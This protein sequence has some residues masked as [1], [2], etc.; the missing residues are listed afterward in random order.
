M[1]YATGTGKRRG[2]PQSATVDT[3]MPLAHE[4]VVQRKKVKES[5]E[6]SDEEPLVLGGAPKSASHLSR[7]RYVE[8]DVT[9]ENCMPPECQGQ[10][11]ICLSCTAFL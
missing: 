5:P 1:H 4:V 8:T 7:T 3:D 2:P 11:F 9:N 10:R 6:S